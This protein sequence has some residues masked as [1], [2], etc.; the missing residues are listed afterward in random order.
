[1]KKE[2]GGWYGFRGSLVE[3]CHSHPFGSGTTGKGEGCKK[4]YEALIE[5]LPDSIKLEVLNVLEEKCR[6]ALK[7][8][9]D[10]EDREKRKMMEKRIKDG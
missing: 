2:I 1:M 4:V 7:V 9:S 6:N 5:G 10:V 3:M 8:A